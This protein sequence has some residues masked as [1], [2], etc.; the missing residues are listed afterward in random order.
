MK[1]KIIKSLVV[2]G[3]SFMPSVALAFD[4]DAYK[5]QF[6]DLATSTKVFCS[7]GSLLTFILNILFGFAGTA[8]VIF[9]ILGGY[10]LITSGGNEERAEKGR[11]T[12]VNAIIG[13]VVII[14]AAT[15]VRIVV[16]AV[17][18]GAS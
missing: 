13:L 18:S 8:A 2:A 5:K 17:T 7:S 6:G 9:I 12:L 16:N 14:L 10:W 11:K 1:S 15:I 4:C 3:L